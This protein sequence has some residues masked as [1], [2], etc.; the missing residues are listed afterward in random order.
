MNG[1]NPDD[2]PAYP[3]GAGFQRGSEASKDGARAVNPKKP[4]QESLCLDFIKGRA[5][6]GATG[7][8]VAQATDIELYIVRARLAGLHKKGLIFGQGRRDGSHGVAVTIWKDAALR[9]PV[10]VEQP[11][12]FDKAA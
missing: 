4:T 10:P 6:L 12:M 9:P 7:D 5:H 3:E 11:D 1:D 8:D 2:L